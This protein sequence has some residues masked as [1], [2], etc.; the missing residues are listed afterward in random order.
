MVNTSLMLEALSPADRQS[1]TGQIVTHKGIRYVHMYPN[2]YFICPWCGTTSKSQNA[3]MKHWN[4]CQIYLAETKSQD[5]EPTFVDQ[6]PASIETSSKRKAP[7]SHFPDTNVNDSEDEEEEQLDDDKPGGSV[8]D[9]DQ[10]SV[11]VIFFIHC[12]AMP[13]CFLLFNGSSLFLSLT[14]VSFVTPP[15]AACLASLGAKQKR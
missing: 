15:I 7:V 14:H 6:K 1:K 2:S 10:H 13:P 9:D 5:E 11:S 3:M 4:K 12:S 8:F